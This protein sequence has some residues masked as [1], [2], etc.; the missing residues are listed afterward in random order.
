MKGNVIH[1]GNRCL[2]WQ[3]GCAIIYTDNNENKRVI[4]EKKE[5]KKVDGVIASI[6]A[7]NSYVQN[8][9]DGD[10]DNWVYYTEEFFVDEA[11]GYDEYSMTHTVNRDD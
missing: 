5:N 1:G 4:K 11:T 10:D 2:R 9:I 3:F 6:I 7:L 8:K